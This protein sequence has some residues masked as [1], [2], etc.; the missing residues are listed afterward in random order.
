MLARLKMPYSLNSKFLIISLLIYLIP[1]INASCGRYGCTEFDNTGAC[2]ECKE[3][4]SL[5]SYGECCQC[6]STCKTCVPS[7]RLYPDDC[8]SCYDGFV[9]GEIDYDGG[10]YCYRCSLSNCAVCET[11]TKCKSCKD[12]YY[13]SNGQ[14]IQ[15]Y[16]NC[17]TCRGTSS[18]DCTGCYDGYY[19][20][21]PDSGS[22]KYCQRCEDN[23]LQ[24]TDENGCQECAEGFYKDS[25]KHCQ[26]CYESCLHCTGPEETQCLECKDG[27][28]YYGG[29]CRECDP[30][31]KTCDGVRNKCTSCHDGYYKD[32]GNLCKPCSANCK[33]CSSSDYC[34]QCQDG[35]YLDPNYN[36]VCNQCPESKN[37]KTCR[38]EGSRNNP[39][40]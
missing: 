21:S 15:C 27:Y 23:C 36:D 17:K 9:L 12:G 13:L 8:L 11:L 16:E 3:G 35:Y 14:C 29:R 26:S 40:I 33:E 25:N 18:S 38:N 20:F 4:Y 22:K 39:S 32:S 24:C 10:S 34:L 5:N 1:S 7:S 2:T 28:Y 6:H 31:C 30:N 37:C 19:L